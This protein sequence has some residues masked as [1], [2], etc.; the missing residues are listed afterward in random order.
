MDSS[1]PEVPDSLDGWVDNTTAFDRV[2]S[3]AMTVDKPMTAPKIAEESIVSPNTARSHLKRLEELRIVVDVGDDNS[4]YRANPLYS[5]FRLRSQLLEEYDRE[6]LI[7]HRADLL[8]RVERVKDEY[9]TSDPSELRER[10][11]EADTAEVVRDLM[12]TASE[13]E[14]VLYRINIVAD[15][16]E[17]Y[18]TYT[19]YVL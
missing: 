5:R 7:N 19:Q 2:Q 3:V 14:S 12:K 16:I 17:Q 1:S 18:E 13:L 11:V 10:A 4:K 8:E 6:G 15:A 9:N